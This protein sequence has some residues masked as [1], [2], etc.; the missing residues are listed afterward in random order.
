[1]HGITSVLTFLVIAVGVLSATFPF[2]WLIIT[3]FKP[4]W[5]IHTYPPMFLPPSITFEHFTGSFF[6]SVA[7]APAMEA[8]KDSLVVAL[9]NTALSLVVSLLVAF[10]ILR[11]K[12]GGRNFSF[13]ILSNRFLPPIAFIIPLFLIMREVQLFDTYVGLIWVYV[14]FNIPFATWLLIGFIQG[15][16][17]ELEDSAMID[18]CSR[19]EAF[20]KVILPLLLPGLAVTVLFCFLFAWNEYMMSLLLTGRM[21][22][23]LPKVL[24]KYRQAHDILYGELSA[25]AIV[26]VAPAIILASMLQKYLVGGLTL[27]AVKY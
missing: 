15:V 23:T 27:G 22:N 11:Y 17:E 8:V 10:T 7:F 16:P 1:M 5:S 4:E 25:A 24:P 3:A 21:V 6:G 13:W 20:R 19:F 18:G 26:A 12:T 14:T 9:G 2:Y